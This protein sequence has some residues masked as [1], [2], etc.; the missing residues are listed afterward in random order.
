[1]TGSNTLR[2]TQRPMGLRRKTNMREHP[3]YLSCG[4]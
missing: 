4:E 2:A 1:M 3:F